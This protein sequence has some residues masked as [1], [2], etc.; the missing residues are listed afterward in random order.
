MG[1]GQLVQYIFGI[2]RRFLFV[3]RN[4]KYQHPNPSEN[5]VT[6]MRVFNRVRF[7]RSNHNQSNN[8][9]SR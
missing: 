8:A 7:S 4:L 3:A 2:A 5:L 9:V 6:P 1:K